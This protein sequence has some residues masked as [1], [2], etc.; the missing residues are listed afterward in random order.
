MDFL[1]VDREP[2]TMSPRKSNMEGMQ[3]ATSYGVE[4]LAVRSESPPITR[5]ALD[6][7]TIVYCKCKKGEIIELTQSEALRSGEK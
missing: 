2:K 3:N 1:P 4:Q 7:S 6:A 5:H